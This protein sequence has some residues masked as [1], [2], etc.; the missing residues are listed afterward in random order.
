MWFV[1]AD[2]TIAKDAVRL[3]CDAA[4][5][6]PDVIPIYAETSGVE[7]IRNKVDCNAKTG[8]EVLLG[9]KWEQCGV[10]NVFRRSFLLRNELRFMPGIYHED[11]EF[12]PRALY[13]ANTIKVVPKV[14]YTV[15]RDPNSITQVPR[16]K[17]AFDYL[18]VAESLL[19]FVEVNGE[20]KTSIGKV[21]YNHVAV[22]INNG[23]YVVSQNSE[24]DCY[25]FNE[26]FKEKEDCFLVPLLASSHLKYRIEGVL[27]KLL[28]G[29]YVSIYRCLQ[30]IK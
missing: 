25:K 28:R 17:R 18:T 22:C 19:H 21:F 8:R 4:N 27:F 9:A 7:R 3:I 26:V 29:R 10:F 12:T 2:D 1:D 20:N 6:H 24:Q 15:Y 5:F 11:A 30:V 23:L 14:L 16:P 13:A